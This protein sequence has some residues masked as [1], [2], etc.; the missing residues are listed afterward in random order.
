MWIAGATLVECTGV[1]MLGRPCATGKF[2]WVT[3]QK[4]LDHILREDLH[5]PGPLLLDGHGS[6]EKV[7]SFYEQ[8]NHEDGWEFMT[9]IEHDQKNLEKENKNI[10]EEAERTHQDHANWVEDMVEDWFEAKIA[11]YIE[12]EEEEECRLWYKDVESPWEREF[13]ARYDVEMKED[14]EFSNMLQEDQANLEQKEKMTEEKNEAS[15]TNGNQGEDM[16]TEEKEAG[17]FVDGLDIGPG[18]ITKVLEFSTLMECRTVGQLAKRFPDDI[19]E[20]L[21]VEYQNYHETQ[22]KEYVEAL[23]NQLF[24][25]DVDYEMGSLARAFTQH[26]GGLRAQESGGGW[27][28][29][30]NCFLCRTFDTDPYSEAGYWGGD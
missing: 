12:E 9:N 20:I 11:Y 6:H 14:E 3:M 13:K 29:N 5:I 24:M 4:Y 18:I 27:H 17:K 21:K 28:V 10:K 7:R 2:V 30:C 26:R 1:R 19:F 16:I 23:E 15:K 22:E 25:F 8:N